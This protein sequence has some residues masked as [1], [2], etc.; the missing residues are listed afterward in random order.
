M[1]RLWYMT[2]AGNPRDGYVHHHAHESPKVMTVPLVI[3][4]VMATV[5]AWNVPWTDL[6]LAPLLQQAQPAGTA[7]GMTGGLLWP[8]IEMPAEHAAHDVHEIA[9]K[10][11]W[12]A[13]GAAL[14]GFLLATLFYGLRKLDPENVRRT[15]APLYWFLSRKWLFDELYAFVFV[16]PVLLV[17]GWVAAL[18]KKCIDWLADYSARAIVV[19]ARLDDWIDRWFVDWMIDAVARWTYTLG[20][21][22]RTIQTGSIRQY[23]LW[24]A[25]GTVGLFVLMSFYWN[26]AMAGV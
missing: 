22:L 9:F 7:E 10:A 5:A 12:A 18:D 14:V 20:L 15:F 11:E 23:V 26:Y 4:A 2:F 17:S 8:G 24:I 1:F 13:F 6:G 21:R 25:V 16:R 19:L 3:L